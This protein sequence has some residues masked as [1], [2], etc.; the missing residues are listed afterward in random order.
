MLIL[1]AVTCLKNHES[2]NHLGHGTITVRPRS[3]YDARMGG[4]MYGRTDIQTYVTTDTRKKIKVD[5]G[6]PGKS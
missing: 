1:I 5:L 4:R 6:A 3:D 2:L